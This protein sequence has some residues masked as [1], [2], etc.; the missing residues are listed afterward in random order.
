M[1]ELRESVRTVKQKHPFE[2][3]AWVVLPEHLHAVWTL[4]ANDADFS[5][6]WMLIKSGFSRRTAGGESISRSRRRKGERG[7]WQRRFWEHEIREEQD[8]AR[9]VD[10]VHFNPVKHGLVEVASR[11][12]WSSIHHEIRRGHL[13][14]DRASADDPGECWGSLRSPPT[15]SR[16]TSRR[17]PS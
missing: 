12:P 7:V 11:W 1:V 5:T 8:L 6:R 14:P 4:P 9:H 16:E 13:T 2:S 17:R 15:C 3:L 10:Y